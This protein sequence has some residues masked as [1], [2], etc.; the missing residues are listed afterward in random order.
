MK[1]VEIEY[2][3]SDLDSHKNEIIQ[4]LKNE[5]QNYVEDMVFRL[6][7]T[8][9]DIA[10]IFDSKYIAALSSGYKIPPRLKENIDIN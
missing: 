4:E 3:L 10:E 9:H 5:E 6:D 7:L 2:N 8:Q 1:I